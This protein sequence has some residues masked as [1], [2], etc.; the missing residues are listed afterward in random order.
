MLNA[1][2]ASYSTPSPEIMPDDLPAPAHTAFVGGAFEV[3]SLHQ[4]PAPL[5]GLK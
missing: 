5:L 4:P 2:A 1:Y 3:V